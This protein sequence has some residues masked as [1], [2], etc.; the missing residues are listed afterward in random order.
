MVGRTAG[1]VDRQPNI[2]HAYV[3]NLSIHTLSCGPRAMFEDLLRAWSQNNMKS[4]I[5]KV[6]PF[7]QGKDAFR[8]LQAGAHIGKVV[9]TMK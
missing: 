3:K 9:I 6:F 4:L 5:G 2:L 7:E 1:P 8:Y